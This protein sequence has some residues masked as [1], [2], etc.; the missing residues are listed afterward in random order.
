MS[1]E[2]SSL[3]KAL[4]RRYSRLSRLSRRESRLSR[5][6]SRLSRLSQDVILVSREDGNLLLSGT[7]HL[8]SLSSVILYI[9]FSLYRSTSKPSFIDDHYKFQRLCFSKQT[10]V[11]LWYNE[12]PRDWQSMFAIKNVLLYQGSF[13]YSLLLLGP[14]K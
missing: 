6:E 2:T 7:V 13:Q 4:A 10:T 1:R 8:I 9:V 14:W 5:W 12:G 11:E 3:F